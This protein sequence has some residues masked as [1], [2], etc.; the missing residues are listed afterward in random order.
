LSFARVSD[1]CNH[2]KSTRNPALFALPKSFKN[3]R[4]FS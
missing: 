2:A 3:L 4:T 1:A